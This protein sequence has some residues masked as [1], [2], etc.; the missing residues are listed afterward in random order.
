MLMMAPEFRPYCAGK[1]ELSILNSESVS[2]GGWKVS[3]FCTISFRL[4]PFTSQFVVSSLDPAVLIP[5]D[6]CPRSGKDRNPFTG[7]VTVPGVRR[8]R[9]VKCLPFSGMSCTVFSLITCP[10]LLVVTSTRG[11]PPWT[12]TVVVVV[13]IFSC[14]F[15]VTIVATSS[16]RSVNAHSFKARLGVLHAVHADGKCGEQVLAGIVRGGLGRNARSLIS[17]HHSRAR[18]G[19]AVRVAHRPL[20]SGGRLRL[21]HWHGPRKQAKQHEHLSREPSE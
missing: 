10:M 16:F 11:N 15:L 7:G 14:T 6:P 2:I 18:D 5:N 20:K 21:A 1:A 13:P 3:W 19:I 17:G 9:S 12:S 4:I 8:L